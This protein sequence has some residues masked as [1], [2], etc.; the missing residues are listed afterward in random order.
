LLAT[1]LFSAEALRVDDVGRIRMD[2]LEMADDIQAYVKENWGA[3]NDETLAS[4]SDFEGYRQA[5]LNMYGFG[6]DGIDYDL[7][8]EP[9]KKMD[10]AFGE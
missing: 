4:L 9:E 2:E 8:V 1:Q 5:F 6:F 7:E 10:L 3:I